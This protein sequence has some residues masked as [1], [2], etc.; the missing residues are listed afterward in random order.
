MFSLILSLYS[1]FVRRSS[2]CCKEPADV[3]SQHQSPM[4]PP[5]DSA[6]TRRKGWTVEAEARHN[7][8]TKEWLRSWCY[9]WREKRKISGFLW[10]P[11]RQ[12]CRP[13]EGRHF[14]ADFQ[15][16]LLPH[17]HFASG[18]VQHGVWVKNGSWL[19]YES[20]TYW[21]EARIE[22][23]CRELWLA[24]GIKNNQI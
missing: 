16:N 12:P 20:V 24:N 3:T 17:I 2:L 5:N 22:F 4:T 23:R 6:N 21:Q 13:S 10:Q 19:T 14:L 7:F 1:Y 8:S 11:S 15:L 9:S 18:L